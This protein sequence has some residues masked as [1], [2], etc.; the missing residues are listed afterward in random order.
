MINS[1]RIISMVNFH[2]PYHTVSFE[3]AEGRRS[4]AGF[5][6]VELLVSMCVSLMLL[7]GVV[8]LFGTLGESVNDSKSNGEMLHTMR[9]AARHLQSDLGNLSL[10]PDPTETQND[11]QGF[12]E[13]VEGPFDDQV[14][15]S[16]EPQEVQLPDP[17]VVDDQ[18]AGY[19][20]DRPAGVTKSIG[21]GNAGGT[22]NKASLNNKC[23]RAYSKYMNGY[24]EWK[25]T[26]LDS[27]KYRV[28]ITWPTGWT[29][30]WAS[31]HES[32]VPVT[33]TSDE[34]T[35]SVSID[36]TQVPSDLVD[37]ERVNGN[38]NPIQWHDLG[39]IDVTNGQLAVQIGPCGGGYPGG[40]FVF[41]DAIRI[42]C[43][44]LTGGGDDQNEEGDN[45][46]L[47]LLGDCD[48]VLHF[49][50]KTDEGAHEVV[51]F[52]TLMP[53]HENK[54]LADKRYRLHRLEREVNPD[55][56][57]EDDLNSPIGLVKDQ[58]GNPASLMK[59][60]QRENRFA[61]EKR[62]DANGNLQDNNGDGIADCFNP[63]NRQ[64]YE[65]VLNSESYYLDG[66]VRDS[67]GDRTRKTVILENVLAFDVQA[68]DSAAAIRASGNVPLSPDDPGYSSGNVIGQGTFVNLSA[69][70]IENA[71]ITQGSQTHQT[72]NLDDP[73][74]VFYYDSWSGDYVKA[75]DVGFDNDNDGIVDTADDLHEPP[76]YDVPL[77]AV[78]VEIRVQEPVSGKVRSVKV[79]K[80]LGKS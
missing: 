58:R 50:T 56:T 34:N 64:N 44:E 26:G 60:A 65:D 74:Q 19:S 24:G 40:K 6:L 76:P 13:Y 12:F 57:L 16:Q 53:G 1:N 25:K 32:N 30:A 75:G 45:V 31:K 17:V 80:F 70:G 41:A 21:L 27:G 2:Q 59:I 67:E 48:D 35:Q 66:S 49:T 61:H 36:Q 38:G 71:P 43:L 63:V 47:P 5:T 69:A 68:Y 73:S 11:P 9:H 22:Q 79:R 14:P 39:E 54:S 42:E 8:S 28:S 55:A 20:E 62:T 51:W 37:P 77:R 33:L 3:I 10:V 7:G 29:G 52:L 18:D 23:R 4:H 72:M 15:Y 78:Q 46:S